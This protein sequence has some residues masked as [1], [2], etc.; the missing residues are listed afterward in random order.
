MSMACVSLTTTCASRR[1]TCACSRP[2]GP[3]SA[4]GCRSRAWKWM[5]RSSCSRPRTSHSNCRVGRKSC[6]RWTCRSRW[7]SNPC[8]CGACPSSA[9]A[10][11]GCASSAR[12]VA[13]PWATAC[14]TCRSCASTATAARCVSPGCT[15]RATITARRCAA[16]PSCALMR[17]L[18]PA[19]S[20]CWRPAIS[21]TS[22]C[23][24]RARRRHR[25]RR[26][27]AC[28]TAARRRA[29]VSMPRASVCACGSS[30]STMTPP[31]PSTCMAAVPAAA[32]NGRACCNATTSPFASC[33]RA[34]A[35]KKA[36]CPSSRC[37]WSWRR[38]RCG[39][40][41]NCIWKAKRRA[42]TCACAAIDCIS[43]RTAKTPWRWTPAPTCRSAGCWKIGICVAVRSCIATA[44]R[45]R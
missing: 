9:K 28:A 44:R 4:V 22:A 8:R 14:S 17:T 41:G 20:P 21:T 1:N 25:C 32:R 12:T 7:S 29:G 24:C 42:W 11:P 36:S 33:P 5:R 27:C 30:V 40:T 3:C 6:R 45:R 34:C 37:Y 23:S 16:R 2:C 35:W 26:C 31:M 43:N 39:S 10:S 18:R 38:A 13:S 19:V 15:G